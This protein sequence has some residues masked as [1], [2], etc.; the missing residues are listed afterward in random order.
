MQFLLNLLRMKGLYMFLALLTH[1]QEALHKRHLVYCVCIMSVDC[2]TIA[3]N[4]HYTHAIYQ[5]PFV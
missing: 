4:R 1:P 5:V 2:A 3:V